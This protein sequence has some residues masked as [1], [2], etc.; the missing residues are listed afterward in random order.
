MLNLMCNSV[1]VYSRKGLL[2]KNADSSAPHQT[3][4]VQS[5]ECHLLTQSHC[6]DST[7]ISGQKPC[8]NKGNGYISW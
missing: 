1:C 3:L 6:E 8:P 4:T 7:S 2:S 5:L